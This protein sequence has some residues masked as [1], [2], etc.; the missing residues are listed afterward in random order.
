[1]SEARHDHQGEHTCEEIVQLTA[2]YLEGAMTEDETTKFELHLNFCEGC[3]RFV[4]QV[5]TTAAMADRLSERQI[6]AELRAKLVSA[7]RDWKR[8]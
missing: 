6:S 7:F 1:M 2:E 8:A 5:K 3:F 4:D